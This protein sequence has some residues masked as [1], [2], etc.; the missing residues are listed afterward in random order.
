MKSYLGIIPLS[1]KNR[2]KQNQL[3]LT[4]IVISVFLVTGIFSMV[5]AVVWGDRIRTLNKH[6]D[7]HFSINNVSEDILNDIAQEDCIDG[8][9]RYDS[10]NEDLDEEYYI[11]GKRVVLCCCDEDYTEMNL[12]FDKNSYPRKSEEI[13]LNSSMRTI[14]GINKGDTVV[15]TTPKGEHEMVVSGFINDDSLDLYDAAGAFVTVESFRDIIGP[16]GSSDGLI[17][18]YKVKNDYAAGQNMEEI[19]AKYRILDSSMNGNTMLLALYGNIGGNASGN[20]KY[21]CGYN[22]YQKKNRNNV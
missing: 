21:T 3:T 7:W 5:D 14:L 4:C 1:A 9:S 20:H 10:V 13:V 12:N 11:N 19:K 6:G 2:K 18:C 17:G 22:K 15:L 16:N 8:Y